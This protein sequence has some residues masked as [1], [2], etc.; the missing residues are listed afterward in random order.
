MDWSA[1]TDWGMVCQRAAGRRKFNELRQ[2][3]ACSGSSRCGNLWLA[4]GNY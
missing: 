2:A 4:W 3:L 1:P